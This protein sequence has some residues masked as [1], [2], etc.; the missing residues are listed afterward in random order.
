[1]AACFEGSRRCRSRTGS[2]PGE[3]ANRALRSD[4]VGTSV[5]DQVGW[6]RETDQTSQRNCQTSRDATRGRLC[7]SELD[8]RGRQAYGFR[9]EIKLKSEIPANG[10]LSHMVMLSLPREKGKAFT[11]IQILLS[12]TLKHFLPLRVRAR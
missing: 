4:P 9:V 7:R 1:L 2:G 8:T 6:R 11:G 10:L 3:T 12:P 5:S